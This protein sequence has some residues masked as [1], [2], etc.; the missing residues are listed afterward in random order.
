MMRLPEDWW[1]RL[2]IDRSGAVSTVENTKKVTGYVPVKRGLDLV[3]ATVLLV[4]ASPFI[5]CG[6]IAVGIDSGLP[7]LHRRRVVGK[8]GRAFDAFKLRTMV[9]DADR[10]L[11]ENESLRAA[12]AAS[13]KLPRDP[14]TTRVG[15]WLRRLS[16]DELP[17][18]VNVIRGEMSLVG[19]RMITPAELP[20]WGETAPLMLSVRPGLTGLWQVSGRQRL[21]KADR[22]RLDDDYIRQMS[23]RLDLTILARTVPA[24]LSSRGA[25]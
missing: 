23:L 15:R 7:L 24:V 21:T 11:E 8:G 18:L 13:N 3:G 25:Y 10:M 4:L 12:F 6:L 2:G 14:R 19:P 20:E 5:A 16:L 1:H 17:Q 9:K 22:I